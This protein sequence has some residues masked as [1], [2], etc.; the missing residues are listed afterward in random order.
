MALSIISP[1]QS[2]VQFNETGTLNH[3]LFGDYAFPLPVYEYTDVA[4]QFYLTGTSSDIDAL[5]GPY[6]TDVRVGIINDCEDADFL[7]EF[8]G[9]PYNDAPEIFRLSDTQLLVNWPHGLPGFDSVISVEECFKIRIQVDDETWCSNVHKR[10]N[11]NCFTSVIDYT[12]DENF[13]GFN[14]CSSG[15][16]DGGESESCDPTIIQFTNVSTLTVPYTQS[17]K[18]KYGDAP[19]VKAYISDGTSLVDMGITITLD[20]Y[21]ANTIS[22]DFGGP[23]SGILIIK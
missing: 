5:C 23:A 22:A 16:V 21:P 1:P 11:D 3:C 4:F 18:D 14:Y 15:T 20:D 10:I 9:N 19:Y 17:L 8:T 6:G 13:A 2:F 7:T 12:N